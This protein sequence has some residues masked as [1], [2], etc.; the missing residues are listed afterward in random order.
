MADQNI[1]NRLIRLSD[2][3]GGNQQPA[4]RFLTQINISAGKLLPVYLRKNFLCHR[5]L[6]LGRILLPE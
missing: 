1:I 2:I 3:N 4:L 5:L 6:C